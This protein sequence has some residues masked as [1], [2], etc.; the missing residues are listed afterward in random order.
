MNHCKNE[1][2][3][4]VPQLTLF[5]YDAL[6]RHPL[7]TVVLANTFIYPAVLLLLALSL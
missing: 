3:Q 4:M 1:H 6:T 2:D 7:R 5:S